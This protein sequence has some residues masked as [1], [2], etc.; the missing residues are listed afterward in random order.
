MS[1]RLHSANPVECSAARVK[2]FLSQNKIGSYDSANRT[3]HQ[4]VYLNNA[5][6]SQSDV[7]RTANCIDRG[8]Q[9][10]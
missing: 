6:E 10:D 8:W 9:F 4:A 1:N 3:S 2:E 7:L 5:G